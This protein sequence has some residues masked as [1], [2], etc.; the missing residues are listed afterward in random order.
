MLEL[1]IAMALL[2]ALLAVAWSLLATYRNA[3][4]RGWDLS[5]RTQT[6]R[7]I[8]QW[9]EE[10]LMQVVAPERSSRVT[11]LATLASGESNGFFSSGPQPAGSGNQDAVPHFVGNPQ[12]F[13]TMVD[14]S[15]DPLPFLERLLS[16]E[17][18]ELGIEAQVAGESELSSSSL[19][20]EGSAGPWP[21]GPVTVEYRLKS[22]HPNEPASRAT[23]SGDAGP[24]EQQPD[25]WSLV[26]TER[27][28]LRN[29]MNVDSASGLETPLGPSEQTLTAQDLYR[30]TDE[31]LTA[32]SFVLQE[33]TVPGLAQVRFAYW[34][35]TQ[36]KA[37]WN[38]A[39]EGRLPLAVSITLNLSPERSRFLRSESSAEIDTDFAYDALTSDESF[40]GLD[41]QVDE[42]FGDG[43]GNAQ[44]L[45]NDARIVV[46]LGPTS[47]WA[48]RR[49]Q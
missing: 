17:G 10:D 48:K 49:D 11:E 20:M 33:A 36:W 38:S 42:S 32:D 35:G 7:V 21:S 14:A 47:G 26:R 43:V 22:M 45:P 5:Q 1:L 29:A 2:V 18:S 40:V 46:R 28:V 16:S 24:N 39:S 3:E 9:L 30:Q 23:Q 27:A 8:R 25:T 34:D 6:V 41:S 13:T 31:R 37:G 44:Q 4:Q 15:I 19:N 12:G